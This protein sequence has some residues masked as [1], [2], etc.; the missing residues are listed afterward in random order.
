MR[1]MIDHYDD[2]NFLTTTFTLVL[3]IRR[4]IEV[5]NSWNIVNMF[6]ENAKCERHNLELHGQ[7][8]G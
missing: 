4:G 1:P 5:Q 3:S 7:S 6:P 2:V 8:T